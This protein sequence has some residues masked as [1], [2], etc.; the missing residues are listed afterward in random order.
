[1]KRIVI[2]THGK[3]CEGLLDT[4]QMFVGD[5]HLVTAIGLDGRGSENFTERLATYFEDN[6]GAEFLVLADIFGGT[7]FQTAM[8][9]KL[10]KNL[11]MEIGYGVNF[12]MC[13]EATLGLETLPLAEL[14]AKCV[15]TG[16]SAID[17]ANL[18]INISD[19]D[20]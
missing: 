5:T 13:L 1:M 17:V 16:K 19:D 4:L 2:V 20:E 6:S 15:E 11:Q 12:P 8:K 10:E 14:A 18:N 3:L 9:L 7:P